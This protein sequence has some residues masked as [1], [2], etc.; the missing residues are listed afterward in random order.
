MLMTWT[1]VVPLSM[2]LI[3]AGIRASGTSKTTPCIATGGLSRVRLNCPINQG[4]YSFRLKCMKPMLAG[5]QK[6][7]K[8]ETAGVDVPTGC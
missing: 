4:R 7:D 8:I 1:R 5:G 6:H 2:S 3:A